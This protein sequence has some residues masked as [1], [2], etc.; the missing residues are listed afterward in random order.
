MK[1]NKVGSFRRHESRLQT[2]QNSTFLATPVDNGSNEKLFVIAQLQ[3]NVTH[4]K[5][6]QLPWIRRKTASQSQ[7]CP[8]TSTCFSTFVV[9][10]IQTDGA[11]TGVLPQLRAH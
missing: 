9:P 7:K 6:S 8:L 1:V 11:Q 5:R 4:E 3:D 10:C 2:L